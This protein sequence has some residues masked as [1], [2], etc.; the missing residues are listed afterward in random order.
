MTP[1]VSIEQLGKRY[2]VARTKPGKSWKD[3][4]SRWQRTRAWFSRKSPAEGQE[5]SAYR[6]LWALKDV[7]FS[8][9]PGTILG[10]VGPN[11]AGKSTLL[12]LLARVTAPTTGRVRGRGRVVSLIEL[13]AG[14]DADSSARENI[15]INAALYG[16][17]KAVVRRRFDEIIAFAE[18]GEFVDVPLNYFS[19]GMF[20]RLAFSVAINMEPDI[21]L[22]DEILAVGDLSFQQRC[23]ARVTEAAAQGLTVFF[24]SHDME[25][26]TRISDRAIWLS[27]GGLLMDGQPDE[28]VSDYQRASF[29]AG[30]EKARQDGAN[31]NG[32][33]VEVRLINAAG[34]EVAAVSRFEEAT[35]RMRFRT[36]PWNVRSRCSI[37]LYTRGVHVLR[38]AQSEFVHV[39]AETVHEV[40]VRIPARFLSETMYHVNVNILF[41]KG[42]RTE[43]PLQ[44][45]KALSFL[46]YG[47][48]PSGRLAGGLEHKRG[49]VG[50]VTPDLEWIPPEEYIPPEDYKS[51]ES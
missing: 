22:A 6:D 51:D 20:I 39:R 45:S 36:G 43:Q 46:V 30:E 16:I 35:I 14:F 49:G 1:L 31:K 26:I 40:T 17:P 41:I 2:R 23:L 3:V 37:D 4:Q 27:G 24:V 21:L 12:K 9:D 13:G 47:E 10:V 29:E 34:R 38:S 7:S 42:A 28:V 11:G 8:V 33:I 25:A 5:T 15:F 19:S 44:Q 48:S 18:L 32:D 50:V